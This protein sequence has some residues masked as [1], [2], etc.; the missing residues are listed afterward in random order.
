LAV[1]LKQKR[2]LK[3]H[4]LVAL[5]CDREFKSA[6]L[7]GKQLQNQI[8]RVLK[9]NWLS[10]R[11]VG[12]LIAITSFS[13]PSKSLDIANSEQPKFFEGVDLMIPL[14]KIWPKNE[15]DVTKNLYFDELIQLS[16]SENVEGSVELNQNLLCG[17]EF[18]KK[19]N[20]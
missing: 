11:P 7:D 16:L 8:R 14:S 19:C 3:Q 13:V 15:I 6:F 10:K 12:S 20:S 2:L 17:Y 1:K 9:I 4:W 18:S 5:T